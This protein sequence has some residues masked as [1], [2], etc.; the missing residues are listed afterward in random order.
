MC[1]VIVGGEYLRVNCWFNDNFLNELDKCAKAHNMSRSEFITLCCSYCMIMPL[2]LSKFSTKK[3][4]IKS[5]FSDE[6]SPDEKEVLLENLTQSLND[7][8]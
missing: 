8:N 2:G 7:D 1:I 5:L 3:Y 6:L 4:L